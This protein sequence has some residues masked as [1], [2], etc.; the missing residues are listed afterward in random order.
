MGYQKI[1]FTLTD[2][3]IEIV[4]RRSSSSRKQGEWLSSAIADYDQILEGTPSLETANAGMLEQVSIRIAVIEKQ[5][6]KLIS[7]QRELIDRK[8]TVSM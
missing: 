2:E 1:H 8:N 7:L 6:S 3:A 4:S 5:L